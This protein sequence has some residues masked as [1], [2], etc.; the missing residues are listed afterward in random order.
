[1]DG[2]SSS[3]SAIVFTSITEIRSG[4]LNLADPVSV[5]AVSTTSSADTLNLAV[6]QEANHINRFRR[7]RLGND[8][9]LTKKTLRLLLKRRFKKLLNDSDPVYPSN[10]NAI[11]HGLLGNVAEDNADIERAS[12]HWEVC[13]GLLEEELDASRGAA[14]PSLNFDP[15]ASNSRVPNML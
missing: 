15:S 8:L 12:Y 4:D 1:M 9:A 5:T 3:T 7:Y 11:K 13:R 2:S 14:K 6:S 10:L